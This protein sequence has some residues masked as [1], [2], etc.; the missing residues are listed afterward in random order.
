MRA[1]W[2]LLA[3]VLLAGC[4][5]TPSKEDLPKVPARTDWARWPPGA[6][7]GEVSA[8]DV[9][10]HGHVFVLHRP[11]RDWAEPFPSEPIAAPVVAMFDAS[12][13]LLARWGSGETVMPHGLSVAPDDSVWIT[14]AQREQLLRFGHDG[15]LM[16]TRGERGVSGNDSAHFGRP[17]DIAAT[18]QALYVAD[19]YLNHRIL[20]LADAVTQWGG[21]DSAEVGHHVP[22]SVA[23]SKERV[24][25]AD[26]ENSRIKIYDDTGRVLR[27]IP[28][29]GHPY[30]AKALPDGRIVSV[31]GRDRIGREGAILRLWSTAG[32]PLAALDVAPDG[33]TR[34]HDLAIGP[35]GTIY[36][37]D[38]AG[39]R[40]LTLPI[41]ALTK[42]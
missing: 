25:V 17:T 7:V 11:G 8:V 30:A 42:D 39:R 3:V 6:E 35:D 16:E 2:A 24:I 33:P 37:A 40:V 9:D 4:S 41:S 5:A 10:S 22:H 1:W 15:A 13:K 34:G 38:V 21:D 31:E 14:D 19:G 29:P 26:R 18:P 36:I 23:V 20:R 27:I 12:G 32:E 28:T